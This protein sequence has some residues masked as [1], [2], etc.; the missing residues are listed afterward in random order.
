MKGI[1]SYQ[2]SICEEKVSFSQLKKIVR[3]KAKPN[4][5]HMNCLENTDELSVLLLLWENV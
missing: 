5:H 3:K 4:V 2:Y 1:F